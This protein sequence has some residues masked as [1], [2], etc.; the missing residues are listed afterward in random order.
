LDSAVAQYT[1][2]VLGY[3]FSLFG[4]LINKTKTEFIT[5]TG[6]KPIHQLTDTSYNCMSTKYGLTNAEN[7]KIKTNCGNC[8][9]EVQAGS[10]K[11]T[12]CLKGV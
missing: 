9:L 4:V 10:M 12:N 3:N 7:K 6:S 1:L 5:M 11:N 2:N 8:G